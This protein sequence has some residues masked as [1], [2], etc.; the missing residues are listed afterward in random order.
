[1]GLIIGTILAFLFLDPPWQYLA[2]IPLVLWE[3]FELYLFMKLRGI[4]S[5]TGP[6][7]LVG[8]RGRAVTDCNP[9]GQVRIRGEVWRGRC[10]D[11]VKAGE[12]V[13]VASVTGLSLKVFPV[14]PSRPDPGSTGAVDTESSTT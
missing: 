14:R 1:V 4:P 13:E 7:A 3:V 5:V 9:D 12:E 6:E 11:G 2:L 10:P 8:R